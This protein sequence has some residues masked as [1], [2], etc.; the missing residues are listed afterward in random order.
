MARR[1]SNP[2]SSLDLFLDTVCNTFG[3]ILFIAILIAVQIRQVGEPA[4]TVG[5]S[6]SPETLAQMRQTADELAREID[7]AGTLLQTI[8]QTMPAPVDEAERSR[9]DEYGRLTEKQGKLATE[10]ARLLA[11]HLDLAQKNAQKSEE[12]RQAERRLRE[13]ESRESELDSKIRQYR[14]DNRR[15]QDERDKT[16]KRVEELERQYAENEKNLRDKN[17]PD[18]HARSEELY[19]PKLRTVEGKRAF[20]IVLRYKR[21][22]RADDRDDFLHKD[23]ELGIPK[24]G[25]GLPLILNDAS[26]TAALAGLLARFSSRDRYVSVIV[27]G[28]SADVFHLVRDAVVKAGLEYELLPSEDG[29]HWYF[30]QRSGSGQVQ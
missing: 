7:S 16:Q 24:P 11:E 2:P 10:K 30:G 18:E 1:R 25:R 19:L 15:M 28:D 23:N 12:L 4:E 14:A 5:E 17:N 22:Y 27:Y 8:R 29:T 20:Y 13:L 3:G 26:T 6:C 21:L 9:W